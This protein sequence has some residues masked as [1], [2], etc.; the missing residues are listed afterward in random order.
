MYIYRN[1]I[2]CP[3]P[4]ATRKP[5][6]VCVSILYALLQNKIFFNLFVLHFYNIVLLLFPSITPYK[7]FRKFM[8]L[9]K[10]QSCMQQLKW[11]KQLFFSSDST[12]GWCWIFMNIYTSISIASISFTGRMK[13]IPRWT[14]LALSPRK[15]TE[16]TND[17]R[18]PRYF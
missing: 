2:C 10:N 18:N 4:I 14:P 8:N 17:V 15:G 3:M 9:A 16:N 12:E 6:T 7:T 11:K 5:N 1:S 13:F